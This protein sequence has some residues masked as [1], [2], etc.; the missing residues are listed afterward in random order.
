MGL[1]NKIRYGFVFWPFALVMGTLAYLTSKTVP[2]FSPNL[3]LYRYCDVHPAA[4]SLMA[5]PNPI[6]L[7]IFVVLGS[8]GWIRTMLWVLSPKAVTDTET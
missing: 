1:A 8:I 3:T 4:G 6:L 2:C 7:M 5:G